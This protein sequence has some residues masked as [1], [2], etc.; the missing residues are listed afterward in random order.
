VRAEAHPRRTVIALLLTFSFV[1]LNGFFVAAE[2]ALVKLRATQL[3]RL[4]RRSD[5]AAVTV[6]GIAAQLDRYLS[7]TQLGIT[8]A[9]LGLGWV[10]EPA[11]AHLLE[12][13][14]IKAGMPVT[15]TIHSVAVA[16]GFTVL[17]AL[18]ILFGELLPKLLA[19]Q[20]AEG[21][22]L[23]VG[24]PLK[25]FHFLTYPA[26][27]ALNAAS[28]LLLRA[29]GRGSIT[30]IEGAL[31]EEE[32]LGILTQAY[33]KGRLS[34]PKRQL[35]ERV[36]Q[37]NERTVRQVMVPRMDVSSLSASL[38]VE[39]AI[40]RARSLGFT[41]YPLVE[42]NDLDKVLGYVNVKDLLLSERP[43]T[44]L[45]EVMREAMLAPETLGLF[46][47]MRD[48]QRR[49]VPL[50]VVVDEY[51]GTSG[52]ATLEDVLE[53][54]V[55]EIRDEHDDEAPAVSQ[56]AD[57]AWTA[58][59]L[60][61]LH[62]LRAAGVDLPSMDADTVGGAVLESLGRLARAGDAVRI[63]EWDVRVET[64]RRRRVSRVML[65]RRSPS[66]VPPDR[67]GETE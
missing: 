40:A 60:I 31:S 27:V 11:I 19:I 17:T 57:G 34:K 64:V 44:S 6:V 29:M 45:R 21:V 61:T 14:A 25:A 52:I 10:G 12:G 8:L 35:L 28:S 7:A 1:V 48:M 15:P 33:A 39:E 38:S 67:E 20:S 50:A 46:D 66:E 65:R 24:R 51:G 32:I 13:L 47:L 37:F 55:G 9:S 49:Q 30:D 53:E 5:A 58:D 59:G 16:V 2:F 23:A 41:R 26:L 56:R 43:P 18:H 62:D 4:A 22:A 3:D 36:M 54:I 63:G 42:G